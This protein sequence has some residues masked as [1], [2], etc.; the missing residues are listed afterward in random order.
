MPGE[1]AAVPSR[2]VQDAFDRAAHLYCTACDSYPSLARIND[3]H[4]FV[5][6]CT[7]DDGPFDPVP[8]A[9][10]DEFPAEWEFITPA[11][12]S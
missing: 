3:D 2:S 5:C 10:F 7:H 12:E 9:E 11:D 8:I 4:V 1:N 6:R